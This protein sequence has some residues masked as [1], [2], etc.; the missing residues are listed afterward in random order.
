MKTFDCDGFLSDPVG[1]RTSRPGG[2]PSGPLRPWWRGPV[3][4]QGYIWPNAVP[5]STFGTMWAFCL[6]AA[7][8]AAGAS[9]TS[10]DAAAAALKP[11]VARGRLLVSTAQVRDEPRCHVAAEIQSPVLFVL[12]CRPPVW[13]DDPSRKC[14]SSTRSSWSDGRCSI[15]VP[16]WV[17]RDL[18]PP[19]PSCRGEEES[20][21][22]AEFLAAPP[23]LLFP[24]KNSTCTATTWSTI[25]R[26]RRIPVWF[27][28]TKRTRL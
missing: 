3:Q 9:E 27:S 14:R 2:P 7:A 12:C 8:L 25:R 20:A 24:L 21:E 11:S 10:D 22:R 18:C 6:L 1:V 17:S 4:R 13:S 15:L 5:E 28:T 19:G 23:H 26:R 16:L